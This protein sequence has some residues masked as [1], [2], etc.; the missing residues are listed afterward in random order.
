MLAL[1][2]IVVSFPDF[3]FVSPG[4]RCPPQGPETQVLVV[5]RVCADPLMAAHEAAP[6]PALRGP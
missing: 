2:E 5:R 1:T 6:C 3:V 4:Q